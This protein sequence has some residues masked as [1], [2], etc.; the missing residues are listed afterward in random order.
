MRTALWFSA[1]GTP[2]TGLLLPYTAQSPSL[3]KRIRF[4]SKKDVYD[5]IYRILS[6]DNVKKFGLGKSLYFQL[7][8]FCDPATIISDWCWQMIEDYHMIKTYNIPLCSNLNKLDVFTS[9]CF[10]QIEN[11]LEEIKKYKASE[12]GN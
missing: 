2:S 10:I 5:E 12:N 4:E 6:E 8:F 3:F 1:F 11:E 7:P 9:D